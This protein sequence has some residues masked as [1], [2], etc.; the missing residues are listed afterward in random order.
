MLSFGLAS[1][2]LTI[3]S[4]GLQAQQPMPASARDS[5]ASQSTSQQS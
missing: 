5:D 1:S 2:L 3:T 4:Q